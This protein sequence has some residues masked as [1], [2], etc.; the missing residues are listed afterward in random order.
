MKT[1][2]YVAIAL[3]AVF[4][5]IFVLNAFGLEMFKYF[6]PRWKLACLPAQ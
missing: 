3:G 5:L 6:A 1:V 4:A 2:R